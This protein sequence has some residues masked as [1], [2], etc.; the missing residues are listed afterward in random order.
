MR[1]RTRRRRIA[2]L[3]TL[4]LSTSC[5]STCNGPSGRT[6]ESTVR[7]ALDAFALAGGTAWAGVN[8]A[9]IYRQASIEG[10]AE[11]R[12]ITTAE[13]R[14]RIAPVRARCHQLT[15]LFLDMRQAHDQA[16]DL[17]DAGKLDEAA[18]WLAK[19]REGWR[20]A[21]ELE[22]WAAAE[23]AGAPPAGAVVVEPAGATLLDGGA[24]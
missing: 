16:A 18:L 22:A 17:V 19:L 23:D 13:A 15:A 14:A 6:S 8:E 9:C 4:A 5:G 12:R 3:L 21:G 11:A 20:T 7:A 2:A 1:E 10:E 24:L